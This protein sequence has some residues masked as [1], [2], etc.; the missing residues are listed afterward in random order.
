MDSDPM[1]GYEVSSL[2]SDDFREMLIEYDDTDG[3]QHAGEEGDWSTEDEDDSDDDDDSM[4][5]LIDPSDTDTPKSSSESK[6][7][8]EENDGKPE[9][10]TASDTNTPMTD[11]TPMAQVSP[12]LPG[13]PAPF[14]VLETPAPSSHHYISSP[15]TASPTFIRNI[16]KEHNILSTSLPPEIFVRTWESRLDLLRILIIGPQDTPYEY[17]PFIIDIHL[18]FTY[19]I[20][21]PEAYFHSWTGGNGPVNPNLYEDGK[22]CLSLLGT[23]HSEDKGEGWSNGKSTLL[24]VLVSILGLVLVKEPYYNEAGYDVQRGAPE[25]KL[26]SALYTERA[27]FR[28]RAFIVHALTHEVDSFAEELQYLYRSTEQGAPQLLDKAVDAAKAIVARSETGEETGPRDGLRK[29]SLGAL[30]MLKRQLGQLEAL[31]KK[32]TTDT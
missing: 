18:P 24:Q 3:E 11:D 15:S 2:D 28:A 31:Q 8:D 14:I 9:S 16:A 27:Y 13:A 5:D 7:P 17:A 20:T 30:V 23:W 1:N 26:S 10:E 4:P 32:T 12:S 19:P 25:T 29:V 21:P 22:I 6:L